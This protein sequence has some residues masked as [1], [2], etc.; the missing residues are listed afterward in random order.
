MAVE[1]TSSGLDRILDLDADLELLSTGYNVT[2]GP[3]WLPEDGCLLFSDMR[4]NRRLTWTP[5][6]GAGS[7]AEVR[8]P[9]NETNGMTKDIHG[10]LLSCESGARRVTRLEPA[11]DITVV[12]NQHNGLA[13]NRPNDVAA[14]ADGSIYFTDPGRGMPLAQR[15]QQHSSVFWVSPDLGSHFLLADD[16]VYPNGLAFSPDESILYV[17]DSQRQHIRVFDLHETGSLER[18]TERIFFQFQTELPGVPDGMAVDVEGNLYCTGP[19]GVWIITP[20]GEHLGTILTGSRQTTNCAFGG[21]GLSTLFVTTIDSLF[22]IETTA[23][24]FTF[25][26]T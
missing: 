11:G 26:K 15:Q 21:E 23:K 1:R 3:L 2:E 10:R 7:V 16:F 9:T 6:E 14:R 12:M 25:P 22:R 20:S 17:D 5:D 4:G 18:Q 8:S 24:G 19:G 13:L